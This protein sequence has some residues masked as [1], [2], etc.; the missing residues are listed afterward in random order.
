[1]HPL[2]TLCLHRLQRLCSAAADGMEPNTGPPGPKGEGAGPHLAHGLQHTQDQL[3]ALTKVGLQQEGAPG[4]CR[5]SCAKLAGGHTARPPC[6][7]L[8]LPRCDQAPFQPTRPACRLHRQ[9]YTLSPRLGAAGARTLIWLASFS[10]S[11]VPLGRARSSR[12]SP[13]SAIRVTNPSS[14][15][16]SSVYSAR[17]TLGTCRMGRRAGGGGGEAW[18]ARG[19]DPKLRCCA[20]CAQLGQA[21]AHGERWVAA[22]ATAGALLQRLAPSRQRLRPAAVPRPRG[23][24]PPAAPPGCCCCCCC[25][26]RG[27]RA[28]VPHIH[29]VGGGGHLLVL[30]AGEDVNAHKVALGVAVLAGLGGG[31]IHDLRGGRPLPGPSGC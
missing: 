7:C 31:H 16:S 25:C 19:R 2:S 27:S 14:L 17:D 21:S 4:R 11:S 29:V 24:L 13:F 18:Q 5:V 6:G 23:D 26:R 1:M 28:P 10:D 8:R 9:P 20:P 22:L 15:M 12:V 3:L 30:L